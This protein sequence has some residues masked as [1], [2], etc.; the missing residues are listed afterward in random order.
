MIGTTEVVV[1]LDKLAVM[2]LQKHKV[3][4]FTTRGVWRQF[5]QYAK[6]LSKCMV[7][8]GEACKAFKRR[9]SFGALCCPLGFWL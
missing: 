8:E 5:V 6:K 1:E 2:Q 3:T 4:C 9:Y 7:Q